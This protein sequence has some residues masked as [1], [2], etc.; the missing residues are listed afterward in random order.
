MPGTSGRP[1]R[2]T[3]MVAL[4][5]AR[6]IPDE[7]AAEFA[8]LPSKAKDLYHRRRAALEPVLSAGRGE[9]TPSILRA[10]GALG[11]PYKTA[12]GLWDRWR[13]SGFDW[14]VLA[15]G[16]SA[17]RDAAQI[18][19]GVVK[20]IADRAADYQRKTAPAVRDFIDGWAARSP[21][22]GA[23]PGLEGFPGWP[24]LPPGCSPRNLKRVA[25][26]P[27]D[28]AMPRQGRQAMKRFLP[29]RIATRA[30]LRVGQYLAI[31]DQEHD[32]KIV[33]P[34]VQRKHLRPLSLDVSEMLTGHFTTHLHK[35]AI[36]DAVEEAKQK[37]RKRDTV[38]AIAG[39]L[40]SH[41]YRTD[42]TG[43]T[44]ITE[45][46]TGALPD[47]FVARLSDALGI[48]VDGAGVDR[49]AALAGQLQ[50][51]A[52][53]N[54]R[55]KAYHESAYNMLRNLCAALPG[56]TGMCPA[57]APEDGE[58]RD[59]RAA[60]LLMAQAALPTDLAPLVQFGYLTWSQ[61]LRVID[62][63][64]DRL[65]SVTDHDLEGWDELGFHAAEYRLGPGEPWRPLSAVAAL[66]PA[67]RDAISAAISADSSLINMRRMSRREAWD[68]LRHELTPL[69]HW[70]LGE[71]LPEDFAFEAKLSEQRWFDFQSAD[72]GPGHHV[73][74][75]RV[76]TPDGR[77]EMLR[78]GQAY[79]CFANPLDPDHLIVCDGRFRVLG[80]SD[81][82]RRAVRGDASAD[83]EHFR[84]YQTYHAEVAAQFAGHG[85]R[86]LDA[87]LAMLR[88]NVAVFGAAAPPER[89]PSDRE[90]ATR[91]DLAISAAA[92]RGGAKTETETT[93]TM[94]DPTTHA[95]DHDPGPAGDDY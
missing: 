51:P 24:E 65:A 71:I 27:R 64:W 61:W 23:I 54:S 81:R 53:G 95:H 82:V 83:M 11:I 50:G 58:A 68:S 14:R 29:Q 44:I 32:V 90:L 20:W 35:P 73:Y 34:G 17:S 76:I 43:T 22:I 57:M 62:A 45:R 8:G 25:P 72:L 16:R 12:R 41:G 33:M 94:E 26:R 37:L 87:E 28:L 6:H 70:R 30:G 84:R 47:R 56:Q 5:I 59:R 60:G 10:A 55:H 89:S 78:R 9:I 63:A 91:A 69:P 3:D 15:D 36:F 21:A 49:R 88:H 2:G 18:P 40:T 13:K 1:T 48:R 92:R 74:E 7:E 38:W 52:R 42:E 77:P 75:G 80:V 79:M 67:G 4:A 46:G 39:H 66:P 86:K 19:P 85:R 31:D 93:P